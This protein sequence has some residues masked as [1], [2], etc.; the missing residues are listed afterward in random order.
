MRAGDGRRDFGA[1]EE[2]DGERGDVGGV[3]DSDGERAGPPAAA[4]TLALFSPSLLPLLGA[5]AVSSTSDC[6]DAALDRAGTQA[7]D[8]A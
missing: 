8:A 6:D 4:G 1:R 2:D 3:G 7:R 5:P